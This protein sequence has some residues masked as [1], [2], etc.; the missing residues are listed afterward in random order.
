ME[1]L[2]VKKIKSQKRA[3]LLLIVGSS[4]AFLSYINNDNLEKYGNNNYFILG[5]L[6]ML[7]AI[8]IFAFFRSYRKLK[9]IA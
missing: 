2:E 3:A 9:K 1:N 4:I 8:G 6:L 7:N 5:G